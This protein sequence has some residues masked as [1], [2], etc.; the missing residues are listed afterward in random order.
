MSE[1]YNKYYPPS[2]QIVTNMQ[3]ATYDTLILF[4]QKN[5]YVRVRVYV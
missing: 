3:L 1:K 5:S 4:S 2:F